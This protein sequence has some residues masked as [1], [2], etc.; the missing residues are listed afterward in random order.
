MI[1]PALMAALLTV[2]GGLPVDEGGKLDFKI[3]AAGSADRARRASS[4]RRRSA[5]PPTPRCA[6]CRPTCTARRRRTI[7]RWCAAR[8]TI[9][10]RSSPVS[11]RRR[12]SCAATRVATCRSATTRGAVR[13]FRSARRWTQEDNTP[14]TGETSCRPTNSPTSRRR[15]IR[16]RGRRWCSC[17]PVSAR[18]R[19]RAARAV[20]AAGAAERAGH[21]TAA[22]AVSSRHRTR[23]C[24]RT[25]R[26]AIRRAPAPPPPADAPPLPR[27]RRPPGPPSRARVP[28]RATYDQNG[29]FVDPAGGTGVF[30]PGADKL[31]PAENWVD[32]MLAPRQA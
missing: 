7:P 13:R 28:C 1:F 17:R 29:K 22:V 20:P 32:L 24:R 26:D 21:P 6:N 11:G 16:I 3:H 25:A 12:C 30:A 9:R 5:R 10:A 2:G 23:W 14:R 18:A 19:A 27:S 4:R 31:A 15:W 8:A